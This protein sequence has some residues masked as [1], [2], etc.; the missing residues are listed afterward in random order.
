MTSEHRIN[1][2][3]VELPVD[4]RVETWV[5]GL[6][7]HQEAQI[8]DCRKKLAKQK[9]EILK[10][11]Q[12][13]SELQPPLIAQTSTESKATTKPSKEEVENKFGAVGISKGM[14][15][16]CPKCNEVIR[17]EC[18]MRNHLESELNKIR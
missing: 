16:C 5:T 8:D 17:E 3:P 4:T 13:A 2:D 1:R 10:K 18:T 6:L 9:A 15:F 7:Q 12:G 11:K 14:S